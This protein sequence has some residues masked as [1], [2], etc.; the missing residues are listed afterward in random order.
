MSTTQLTS[1]DNLDWGEEFSMRNVL[2]HEALAA[3][4]GINARDLK[5]LSLVRHNKEM[6]TG[7]IA[8]QVGITPGSATTMIDRLEKKGFVRRTSSKDD[9]RKVVVIIVPERQTEIG[10]LYVS[11]GQAVAGLYA[12]YEPQQ[13]IFIAEFMYKMAGIFKQET[14]KL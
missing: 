10:Q 14:E 7:S 4:L 11:F 1:N 8:K 13:I 3:R 12:Q 9:R 6:T 2:F 5:C